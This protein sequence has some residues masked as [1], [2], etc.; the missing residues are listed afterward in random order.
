MA[1]IF[2]L[3][4]LRLD[5]VPQWWQEVTGF[6]A[7]GNCELIALEPALGRRGGVGRGV[8]LEVVFDLGGDQLAGAGNGQSGGLDF[9]PAA[10][11]R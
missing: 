5:L 9:V 7:V 6:V 1:S 11:G 4:G 10:S 3:S 2:L 8:G